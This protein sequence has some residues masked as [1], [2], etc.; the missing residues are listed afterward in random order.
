MIPRHSPPFGIGRATLSILSF[1][2]RVDVDQV[3]CKFAETF[4][5]PYAI[6]LPSVRAG[7]SWALRASIEPGTRVIC[8]AYTC[9]VVHEAVVRAGGQLC[10]IDTQKNSFLMDQTTLRSG[11]TRNCPIV[12]C[13]IYGYTYDLSAIAQNTENTHPIRIVDMAMTVPSSQLV[14]RL[15]EN[16]VGFLSFGIGKCM[17]SGWGGMCFTKNEVL[18]EK[19][20]QIRNSSLVQ[21]SPLLFLERS[22]KVPLRT[23]AHSRILYGFSRKINETRIRGKQKN[24]TKD[25]NDYMWHWKSPGR[26][27]PEWFVPST[28]LDRSLIYY[29]IK[30]AEHYYN[31]RISLANRYH[32][33]LSGASGFILPDVSNFPLSHYTI[34]VDS[35]IRSRLREDLWKIGIDVGT[36]FPLAKYIPKDD[37]PNAS[38]IASEVVNLPLSPCLSFDDIDWI[39]KNLLDG[40]MKLK[41]KL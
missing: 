4:K 3:E 8:P 29:N 34:R 1:L 41:G 9:E 7:I 18:A 32:N 40:I 27:S 16:D 33:N 10:L 17:Y 22:V 2:E 21:G 26:L 37:Y 28:C 12:L 38:K 6:L 20:R 5:I 11:Q 36:L 39:S 31:R 30:H 13:E 23:L 24:Q 15:Q 19:I 35:D 25:K 14:A